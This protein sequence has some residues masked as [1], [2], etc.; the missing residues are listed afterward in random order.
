MKNAIVKAEPAGAIV[1]PMSGSIEL[2]LTA[3]DMRR[4]V[5][6]IQEVM[7]AVMKE[8]THYGKVPGCGDRKALLKPGAEV[9]LTTFRISVTPEVTDM[10]TPDEVRYQVKTVGTT[11]DGLHVG[12]GIGECSSNED[13]Y[14]WRKA[15]CDQEYNETDASRKRTVWKKGNKPPYAPYQLKQVRM[16]PA[17]IAN[18]VLKMAKKRSMVDMTLTATAASDVFEQDIEELPTEYLDQE[19]GAPQKPPIRP[20]QRKAAPASKQEPA[21]AS[22]QVDEN[23]FPEPGSADGPTDGAPLDDLQIMKISDARGKND[24]GPWHITFLQCSDGKVYSTFDDAVAEFAQKA[25]EEK[26]GVLI[27]AAE[28]KTN[29]KGEVYFPIMQIS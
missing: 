20:P 15:V 23:G 8:G 28:G 7:K 17:D 13:K 16:N 9:I 21:P 26:R 11:P 4:R 6:L 10:S 22:E 27:T 24:K 2:P 5:N 25:F 1:A 14:K 29:K 18:T 3:T 19:H 12:T